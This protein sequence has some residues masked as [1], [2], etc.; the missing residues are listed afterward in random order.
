MSYKREREEVF[1]ELGRP[2]SAPAP[3]PVPTAKNRTNQSVVFN[4]HIA[5]ES[6]LSLCA[7]R[8]PSAPRESPVV[9]EVLFVKRWAHLGKDRV[10][11]LRGVAAELAEVDILD[12]PEVLKKWNLDGVLRTFDNQFDPEEEHETDIVVVVQGPTTTRNVF[13]PRPQILD[14]TWIGVVESTPAEMGKL[15]GFRARPSSFFLL[16]F[17]TSQVFEP[18]QSSAPLPGSRVYERPKADVVRGFQRGDNL[19]MIGA[20]RLGKIVDTSPSPGQ[21]TINVDVSWFNTHWLTVVFGVP[22]GPGAGTH[23]ILGKHGPFPVPSSKGPTQAQIDAAKKEF[24][25]AVK[26]LQQ[27]LKKLNAERKKHAEELIR[28]QEAIERLRRIRKKILEKRK[29]AG[30]SGDASGGEEGGGGEG[31]GEEGGDE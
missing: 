8:P 29:A 31:G 6:F 9:G 17:T 21:V 15:P 12:Q 24:D 19:R 27:K 10:A 11:G 30:G 7:P 5:S 23:L 26:V 14:T 1:A 13:T 25:D 20:W 22:F 3:D 28:R 18:E 16:P 2:L 4:R